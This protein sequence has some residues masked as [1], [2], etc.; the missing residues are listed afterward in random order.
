MG[1]AVNPN[2]NLM[3]V[4]NGG[5]NVSVIDGISNTIVATVA[6]SGGPVGWPSTPTLTAS[7]RR[8]MARTPL[9][10]AS[11]SSTAPATRSSPR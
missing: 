8:P 7:T 11:P 2:T 5:A 4:A 3:Y 6:V 1:I 10:T 9:A